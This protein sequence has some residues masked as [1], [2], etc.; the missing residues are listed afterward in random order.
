MLGTCE[1]CNK[2]TRVSQH[3][4]G[5]LLCRDDYLAYSEIAKQNREAGGMVTDSVGSS[6]VTV[7]PEERACVL[8][9]RFEDKPVDM[10]RRVK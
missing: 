9:R 3:P 8:D 6:W 2:E 4:L 10:D 7:T 5:V 1:S